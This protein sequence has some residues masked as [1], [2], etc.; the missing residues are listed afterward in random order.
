MAKNKKEI[1]KI[2]DGF[3]PKQS[4]VTSQGFIKTE[5][6]ETGIETLD[7]L[8][9]GG[10]PRGHIISLATEEGGGKTTLSIQIGGNIVEKYGKYVY[11]FD[12]EGGATPELISS[13]GYGQHV[14]HPETNPTGKFVR[15]KTSTIQDIAKVLKIIVDD[16]DTGL[17]VIDSTTA[18]ADER[19]LDDEFLGLA[20]N[21]VGAHARMWSEASRQINSIIEKSDATLLFIHQVRENLSNFIVRTEAAR[22]RALKHITSVEIF[23]TVGK[24][25]D[26]DGDEIKS[27]EDAKGAT[28]RLTTTKNRLTAPFAKVQL[29]LF[30]GRGVSNKWAY[31]EWLENVDI[32]DES[33]GEITKALFIKGGGYATLTLPSGVYSARGKVEINALVESHIDEILAFIESRGG[34]RLDHLPD[35]VNESSDDIESAF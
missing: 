11:Y 14:Y 17:I 15:M 34:L 26:A 3:V 9:D 19:Q 4:A 18:T 13:M 2:V 22:G 12:V 32:V 1:F 33:T 35:G 16:E 24:W 10:I 5:R 6:F 8:L 7:A 27:R 30:F 20:K 29:P 31:R 25:L 28:L 21:S 23:G